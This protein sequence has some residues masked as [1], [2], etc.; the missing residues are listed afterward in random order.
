MKDGFKNEI[1]PGD[2][3]VSACIQTM[4]CRYIGNVIRPVGIMREATEHA[5]LLADGWKPPEPEY[6]GNPS[7]IV[8]PTNMM[9]KSVWKKEFAI[10]A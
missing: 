4:K 5:Q 3:L 9:R 10:P 7:L 1:A 2:T 6:S 8:V